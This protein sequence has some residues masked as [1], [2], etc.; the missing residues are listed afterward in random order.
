MTAAP[1][2]L[3]VC[4]GVIGLSV[5]LQLRRCGVAVTVAE[6]APDAPGASILKAGALAFSDLEPLAAPA[7]LHI[8]AT[9]DQSR[10][11]P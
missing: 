6:R 1:D 10:S 11:V 9:N 5:A 7:A 2:V 3:F 8:C 4:A